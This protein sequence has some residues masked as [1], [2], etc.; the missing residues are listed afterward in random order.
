MIALTIGTGKWAKLARY[1]AD[2]MHEMTGMEVDVIGDGFANNYPDISHPAWLKCFYRDL[3]GDNDVMLFDA[4]LFA[5]KEWQPERL[6]SGR[7]MVVPDENSREV[8][9][10]CQLY[11]IGYGNYFNTGL[12]IGPEHVADAFA[13]HPQYGRWNE[14]TAINKVVWDAQL[15]PTFLPRAYNRLLWPNMDSYEPEALM[16]MGAVNLHFAS[17][18]DPDKIMEV[19]R[20]L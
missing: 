19:V 16:E 15:C 8:Y 18:G 6:W 3:T 1:S 14:Q 4:D 17:I 13:Y 12:I 2:R 9:N 5:M 20:K 7:M 11:Q 10:E